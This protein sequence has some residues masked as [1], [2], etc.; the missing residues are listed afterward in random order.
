M[1][2]RWHQAVNLAVVLALVFAFWPQPV[3]AAAAPNPQDIVP[4]TGT[5]SDLACHVTIGGTKFQADATVSLTKAGET[6][7]I[8]FNLIVTVDSKIEC[9]FNLSGAATGTWTVD[10][11]NGSL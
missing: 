7:I 5:N 11:Y 6:D 8:G 9:D 3:L 4:S 2:Q 10:V 1:K